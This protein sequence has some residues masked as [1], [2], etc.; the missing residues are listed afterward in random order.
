M[1]HWYVIRTKP[2]QEAIAE[3]NLRQQGY[4]CMLPMMRGYRRRNGQR[5]TITEPCFRGYLFT[6][7]ELGST[8]LAP[9]RSSRGVSGLVRFGERLPPLPQGFMAELQRRMNDDGLVEGATRDFQPGEQVNVISGPLTGYRA[10]F[11]AHDGE[12]RAVLLLDMLGR[13]QR[14]RVPKAALAVQGA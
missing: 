13:E 14:V 6:E 11:E 2:R 8:D 5:V 3:T 9:I 4:G 7:L 10:V 1:K 12:Q